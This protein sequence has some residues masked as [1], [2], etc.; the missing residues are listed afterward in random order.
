MRQD[1]WGKGFPPYPSFTHS[2]STHC[3]LTKYWA[4]FQDILLGNCPVTLLILQVKR[5]PEGSYCVPATHS[6]PSI[7]VR[8]M[9][10]A[11][12]RSVDHS[13]P[14]THGEV[15]AWKAD[16]RLRAI[17]TL[18]LGR[19]HPGDPRPCWALA[20]MGDAGC[21][22]MP[23]PSLLTLRPLSSK[24]ALARI[25]PG[26][27]SSVQRAGSLG[28]GVG[29]LQKPRVLGRSRAGLCPGSRHL[30]RANLATNHTQTVVSLSF[31]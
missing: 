14:V 21:W 1:S 26:D 6:M 7:R 17:S 18:S 31:H 10:M 19:Q 23:G 11:T 15:A 25:C 2:P 27:V 8:P 4:Q 20:Q 5:K 30:H 3:V 13:L 28:V 22:E 29:A 9:L 12:G 16:P 24:P